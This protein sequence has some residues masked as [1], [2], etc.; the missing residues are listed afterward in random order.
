MI[1]VTSKFKNYNKKMLVDNLY[2][3]FLRTVD[4]HLQC[5]ICTA[6]TKCYHTSG[7]QLI[8]R[9]TY[10]VRYISTAYRVIY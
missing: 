8:I 5:K 3:I 7:G 1:V 2:G 6:R 10:S 9:I 4:G